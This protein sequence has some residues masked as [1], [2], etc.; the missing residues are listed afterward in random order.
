MWLVIL[1]HSMRIKSR[2]QVLNQN[3]ARNQVS[4]NQGWMISGTRRL[5]QDE[6]GKSLINFG[7]IL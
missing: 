5:Q 1:S 4:A 6:A 2:L 7:V 3:H